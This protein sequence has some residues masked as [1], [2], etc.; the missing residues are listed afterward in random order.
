MGASE[1]SQA[2]RIPRPHRLTDETQTTVSRAEPSASS[3]SQLARRGPACV[4]AVPAAPVSGF[5]AELRE[6]KRRRGLAEETRI[7]SITGAFP[8]IRKALLS[9]G[10]AENEDRG[11]TMWDLKY[12]LW[13]R[14]IGELGDLDDAQVVNYFS[15]NS[16]LTSKVG[17]AANLYGC[18]T[19]D[20]VD[21]DSFYPRCYDLTS[22]M[23]VNTF[24][25][26]FKA[27]KCCSLLRR[28]VAEGGRTVEGGAA[29]GY[30]RSAIE[31]ALAVTRRRC[32]EVDD[33]LDEAPESLVS[34]GE[35]SKV[36]MWSLK[37]PG[38]KLKPCGRRSQQAPIIHT[39]TAAAAQVAAPAQPCQNCLDDAAGSDASDD[40]AFAGAQAKDTAN[41][42]QPPTR[43]AEDEALLAVVHTTLDA[44]RAR[45]VQY[46]LEGDQNIW[47]LKPSGKSRG[48]GIQ[49]SARLDKIMAVGV[50]RGAEARWVAQKYIENPMILYGKKFDIRQW[51]VVTRWNPLAAW[52]YEDSYLRFSFADYDPT[53]LKNRYAHLTNN[54]I[55]KHA[56]DFDE[57]RDETMWS[58]DEFSK[59]LA[60]L[61]L[62]RDGSVVEDPWLEIVQPKMKEIV[63]RSLECVQDAVLPRASSFELF[64]YDFMVSADLSVWLIEVN[65]SPDCSYST[66]T[67]R[68][69]VKGMLDDL[70]RVV[71]DV[72][73]FGIRPDR[74]K[75]KWGSCN[76]NSGRFALLEP[77]R[78]RRG[79]KLGRI[80]KDAA[81]LAV[82][83]SPVRLRKPRRGELP[84]GSVDA[85][86]DPRFD[87]VQLLAGAL[88]T[89]ETF[90]GDD[91]PPHASGESG[92]A[93]GAGAS[94][95]ASEGEGSE[96]SSSGGAGG[97]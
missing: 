20:R 72:E 57:Q 69:L 50:G 64:G 36:D 78:R 9:R 81:Q 17:L 7:F 55:S 87:A 67:T 34:D 66:S 53:K 12:A 38:R 37:K 97:D 48:R 2:R 45:H 24:I 93:D 52:F 28:F 77:Q 44:M 29:V 15:R 92:C 47:V 61:R 84:R 42:E 19:L 3:S 21:I 75:R 43:C 39:T 51:V 27:T 58:S 31:A 54:S 86:G 18:C 89:D 30:P 22:T 74:P 56:D 25:E 5:T 40:D 73:K 16:E 91:K 46:D 41:L 63:A 32:L 76:V 26:D 94:P 79:E 60:G 11:S 82:H 83:G 49:L 62:E 35:W 65:S 88:V 70:V 68:T 8:G 6:W 85:E 33:V 71:V 80:R 59:Y 96:A 4:A 23:Q 95:A 13:Q 1:I 10:W 90:G 14:D